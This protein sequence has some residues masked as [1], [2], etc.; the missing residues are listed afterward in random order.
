MGKG[1]TGWLSPDG[2][3]Y[4][5]AYGEH[6]ELASECM[7]SDTKLKQERV[8]LSHEQGTVVHA[9]EVLKELLWIVM[10]MPKWG[11]HPSHDYIFLSHLGTTKEQDDWLQ[12]NYGQL[13]EPQ[14]KMVDQHYE[15]M[16]LGQEIRNKRDSK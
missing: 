11:S 8:R 16:K 6:S 12:A 10:G 2:V 9:T 15:D 13:S 14:Q 5:C 4:P 3:F 1:L 7:W